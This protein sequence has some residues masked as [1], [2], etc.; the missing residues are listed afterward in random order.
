MESVTGP[1]DVIW[2]ITYACPLRCF[3]CYSE[4]GRRA[5]RQLGPDGLLRLTEAVL[6]F[7]PRSVT[8]SGGEPL[9]VKGVFEVARRFGEAGVERLLYTSGWTLDETL[10]QQAVANFDRI[11][12][13]LDGATADV[14]DRIRGR[15]G[16]FDR[17]LNALDLLDRAAGDRVPY[18]VDFTVVRSNFDQITDACA[19]LGARFPRLRTIFFGAAVPSGLASRADFAER[20]LLTEEQR[21][22]LV[23]PDFVAGLRA[24]TPGAA[25]V[26]TTDNRVL[27]MH[28]ERV[29][30]AADFPV[31]QVEPDGAVRAMSIYEGTVGNLL[32]DDPDQVWRRAVDRWRDPFVVA[33]LGPA[34]TAVQWAEAARRIDLRFGSD[35]D[36]A[37]IARRPA[38]R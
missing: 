37:R 11:C 36:R 29:R 33:A 31:V 27:Q 12:V 38:H 22:R 19:L 21:E 18:G 8:I 30:S 2:D 28:P 32:T 14:H 4:S 9:L 25:R 16:S 23:D 10:A 6:R 3:H 15:R 35:D 1:K 26:G 17:A 5:A 24:A 20:E 7:Q 13:S 34:H